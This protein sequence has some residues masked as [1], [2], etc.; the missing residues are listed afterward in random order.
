MKVTLITDSSA[1]LV[2]DL[3][4]RFGVR[5]LPIVIHLPSEDL[6]DRMAG[7]SP[8]VYSALARGESVKSSA[9]SP[10]EYLAAIEDADGDAVIVITPAAE[11]TVM[12]RNASLA[13]EIAGRPVTVIDSRTAAAA[14]G[15]VVLAAC[16]AAASCDSPE[17]LVSAVEDASRRAELVAALESVEFIRRSG[18]IPPAALGLARQMGIRP[19]F[20]LKAGMAER[21]GITRSAEAALRRISREWSLRGGPGAGRTAVFHSAAPERAAE[22]LGLLGQKGF[23]TEFSPSMGIH[24]GPGVVGVAWLAPPTL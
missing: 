23:V 4:D 9:P 18:R 1:C 7:A 3:L 20:R 13:A 6:H 2:P 12:Y 21:V 19:V 17:E 22:L 11:F 8:K 24:T 5:I 14:Q 15:L 16:E 10:L